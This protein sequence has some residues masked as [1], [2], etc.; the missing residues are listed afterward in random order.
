VKKR[1]NWL[2]SIAALSLVVSACGQA[3]ATSVSA[4]TTSSSAA[5]TAAPAAD[6]ASAASAA[7][8]AA[9]SG[10]ATDSGE[11]V[12]LTVWT[13]ASTPEVGPPPEDW[14]G[15][16]VIREQLNIN[17]TYALIPQGNDGV[18]KLSAQ[19]SADDLP[20]FFQIT[21]RNLFFQ[22]VDQGQIAP[23]NDVLPLMPERTKARYSDESLNKLVTIDGQIYGFQEPQ[24]FQQRANLLVRQDWLDAL[25]LEAPTT[26]DEFLEVAKAFTEQDPDGNG[27][28]DTFGFG[29]YI[30]PSAENY[31]LGP[32][33]SFIYG[34]YAETFGLTARQ[35]EYQQATA[36]I[37]QLNDARVLDPDWTT[38]KQDDF[39]ARWKQG[40]YGM[41]VE[42]FCAATCAANYKEFD[43]N[44]PSGELVAIA[45]PAGPNG[46]S[47][48][49]TYSPAGNLFVMSQRASDEGKGPAIARL[50]EWMHSGEGYY[51]TGFGEQG[52]DLSADGALEVFP[53]P[54]DKAVADVRRSYTQLKWLALNGNEAEM[55]ARYPAFETGNGR[56][57]D[58]LAYYEI[59]S[60]SP[61]ASTTGVELIQPASMQAD[62]DRYISENLTQ[63]VLSQK[64]L[65]DATWA[66]FI[67]AMDGLGVA[68]WEAQAKQ[69][70][71]EAGLVQ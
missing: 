37:K 7:P 53:W 34:A 22:L 15:Y 16:T 38:I 67:N 41:F 40:K 51:L 11:V 12:D 39:R 54:E 46:E 33:F 20:D 21:N 9:T 71:Q 36:F 59:S 35:P 32:D 24:L 50:L 45:P 42:D 65:D 23:V 68:D 56:T 61:Y 14:P 57:V 49:N 3:P 48:I 66:E 47:Q 30:H 10:A 43:E 6:A 18:T 70:L 64:P 5:S 52:I 4:P 44:N 62:I 29:A 19:A 31:A 8:A 28:N 69:T 58:P 63:F 1:M 55:K 13:N 26:L 2:W 60:N 25:G 17:L 27:Q